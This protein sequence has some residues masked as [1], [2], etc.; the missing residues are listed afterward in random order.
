MYR[1]TGGSKRVLIDLKGSWTEKNMNQPVTNTGG[2]REGQW[3]LWVMK[4]L[5]F[6]KIHY[7]S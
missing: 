7:S 6:R 1:K 5:N 3:Q 2:Y 4:I